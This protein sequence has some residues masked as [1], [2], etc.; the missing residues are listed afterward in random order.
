ME[1]VSLNFDT[2]QLKNLENRFLNAYL[3]HVPLATKRALIDGKDKAKTEVASELRRV[4]K[5]R[6][7][8]KR[9]IM[10]KL[11]K[12][13]II[14][15]DGKNIE[16]YLIRVR[17]PTRSFSLQRFVIG[18][19]QPSV[20]KGRTSGRKGII[21]PAGPPRRKIKVEIY[22]GRQTELKHSFIAK[23]AGRSRSKDGNNFQVF[24]RVGNHGG[25]RGKMVRGATPPISFYA[26]KFLRPVVMPK[27]EKKMQATFLRNIR[28][29]TKGLIR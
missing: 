17:M 29:L 3:N 20:Q 8:P 23:A 18:R 2:K 19:K 6:A 28:N 22:P 1:T 15:L 10:A 11:N 24:S 12:L 13:L 5:S 25:D 7:V 4:L 21:H 9:D 14:H 27:V 16:R 26:K